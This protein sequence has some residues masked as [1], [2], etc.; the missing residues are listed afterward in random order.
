MNELGM[1][2]E[3]KTQR[4]IRNSKEALRD[5]YMSPKARIKSKGDTFHFIGLI[6]ILFCFVLGFG[7]IV[8]ERKAKLIAN[9]SSFFKPE[10]G[11][12]TVIRDVFF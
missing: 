12:H 11:D 4:K 3:D 1:F 9:L 10:P 7:V 5:V 8:Q 2:R 6:W